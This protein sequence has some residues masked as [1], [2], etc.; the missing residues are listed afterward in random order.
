MSCNPILVIEDDVGIRESM[1]DLLQLEG[2]DVLTAENGEIGLR[3]IEDVES[4]C[5]IVLDLMMPVMDGWQFLHALH[6]GTD[7]ERACIP[8]TVVSAAVDVADVGSRFG[9]EVMTKPVDIDRLL[10][11]ARRVCRCRRTVQ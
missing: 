6:D 3:M 9:C 10:D 4:L 7:P 11:T 8:V 5:M 2:Y 1:R